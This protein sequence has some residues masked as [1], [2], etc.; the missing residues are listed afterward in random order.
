MGNSVCQGKAKKTRTSKKVSNTKKISDTNIKKILSGLNMKGIYLNNFHREKDMVTSEVIAQILN[1]KHDIKFIAVFEAFGPKAN[2]ALSIIIAT[3]KEKIK[4]LT[5]DISLFES[6]EIC[7]KRISLMHEEIQKFLPLSVFAYSGVSIL[8]NIYYKN[9]VFS[10][11][12]GSC[13][14]FIYQFNSESKK[15]S[16]LSLGIPHNTN[17]EDEKDRLT[18]RIEYKEMFTNEENLCTYPYRSISNPPTKHLLTRALGFINCRLYGVIDTPEV[19][20]KETNGSDI[21]IFLANS[22][23]HEVISEIEI[24]EKIHNIISPIQHESANKKENQIDYQKIV[25]R[26]LDICHERW[27]NSIDFDKYELIEKESKVKRNRYSTKSSLP[28]VQMRK[29][30]RNFSV[31]NFACS[32]YSLNHI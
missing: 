17:R 28:Q 30:P 4:L 19:V 10:I 6:L 9:K 13:F 1:Y 26:I 22:M 12:L 27:K 21:L 5:K 31:P 14:S 16:M 11:N 24:Y 15:I 2:E 23:V 20:M 25:D 8:A 32:I 7:S 3:Y 29:D 18:E